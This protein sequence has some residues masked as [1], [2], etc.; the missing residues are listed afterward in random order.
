MDRNRIFSLGLACSAS[1]L[2]GA[3]YRNA[4]GNQSLRGA[5]VQARRLLARTERMRAQKQAEM[6]D[7]RKEFNALADCLDS[8]IGPDGDKAR[9]IT[10][11]EDEV[12]CLPRSRAQNLSLDDPRLTFDQL[13]DFYLNL[14]KKAGVR[15]YYKDLL[16][17]IA[18]DIRWAANQARDPEELSTLLRRDLVWPK[19]F[20]VD[21]PLARFK[22]MNPILV[23]LMKHRLRRPASYAPTTA[24]AVIA[25]RYN[26][27]VGVELE[28]TVSY[29]RHFYLDGDYVF[30]IGDLHLEITPEW[31][32]LHPQFPEPKNGQRV[33]VKG[34]TYYD[35]FHKSELEY[36]PKDPVLGEGLR[37]TLWEIHPVQSLGIER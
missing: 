36:N 33:K 8:R 32:L 23:F 35:I 10:M 21:I 30:N 16:R 3:S 4:P 26:V 13:R 19:V 12:S 11:S 18:D 34:W 25:G 7:L 28:G 1:L 17:S 9:M 37:K 5:Q 27:G 31:R 6:A 29:A 14:P 24:Q 20:P 15:L 2:M 22:R